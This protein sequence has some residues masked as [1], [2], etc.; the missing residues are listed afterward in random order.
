LYPEISLLGDNLSQGTSMGRID[1][2]FSNLG[3]LNMLNAKYFIF[4]SGAAP[5]IN[6]HAL[7]K[8]WFVESYS[9]VENADQE[10]ARVGEINT[11]AEAVVDKRF[12]PALNNLKII[13]DS[14]AII[15]QTS[16]SPNVVTYTSKAAS[17]QLAV[18]SEIWYPE[19]E[20]YIDGQKTDLIRAN[21]VLRAAVIPAGEHKVEMKIYPKTFISSTKVSMAS[22]IILLLLTAG[23]LVSVLLKYR[24]TKTATEN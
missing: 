1:S 12:A 16:Y 5:L 19:W 13:P 11:A 15:Q 8:A 7:G 17:P 20:L 6:N 10:I 4:N 23:Y 24:K 14:T 18:F 3:V 21:Y 2:T 9:I 22:S